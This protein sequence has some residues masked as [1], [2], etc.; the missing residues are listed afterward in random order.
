MLAEGDRQGAADAASEA[1]QAARE[2]NPGHIPVALARA[3]AATGINI[4]A[5]HQLDELFALA[6]QTP[7]LGTI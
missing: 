5:S 7:A 6:R 2:K 3:T 1:L 4:A